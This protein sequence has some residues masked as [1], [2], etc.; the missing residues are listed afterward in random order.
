MLQEFNIQLI[1]MTQEQFATEVLE[2]MEP[3]KQQ[4]S[5]ALAR[6]LVARAGGKFLHK[7]TD[8]RTKPDNSAGEFLLGREPTWGDIEAGTAVKR[9]FEGELKGLIDKSDDQLTIVTGTAGTGKS[10]TLMRLALT[11]VA[12]G[13]GV[14][15]L[16][17][18]V[19]VPR[20]HIRNE[21]REAKPDILFIDDADLFNLNTAALLSD[22]VSDNTDMLLVAGMRSTRY[23][24]VQ[25]EVNLKDVPFNFYAVPYLE[26]SDI[27]LLLDALTRANRLGALRGLTR[28]QQ[29]SAFR[30]EAGRQLLVAMIQATSNERFDDKVDSECQEL[31]N[32]LGLIYATVALATSLRNFLTRDEILFS[33]GDM[34]NEALNRVQSLLKQ[35]LLVETNLNQIRVRHRVIAEKA[36]DYY[37]KNGQLREPIR[38]LLWTMATR[39]Q[40][41]QNGHSRESLLLSQ[42]MSHEFMIRLTDDKFTPRIAY[43]DVE[44]VLAWNYHYYLQRGSYEVEIGDLDLAKN[45]LDQARS[46]APDDYKVQTEWAYMTLKRASRDAASVGA[47]ERAEEAFKELEDA[48]SRRGKNDSYPYHVIGSQGLAW[49]RRAII[50]KEEKSRLLTRLRAIADEG[51]RFH[52]KQRDLQKL[53]KDLEREYLMLAVPGF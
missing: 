22:L 29:V 39:V 9:E 35:H 10:T 21:V 15:W 18:D 34:T 23:E 13:K 52:P 45:F 5:M 51:V 32:E 47:G 8:L 27:E 25:V 7:V 49:A 16:D 1:E 19:D 17:S 53:A 48:I 40:P 4:G 3:E 36:L 28:E 37:R 43:N 12:E 41:D 42:V 44:D 33:I 14:W 50:S 20:W 38:G 46:L 2:Q 11:Y 6:R 26:D 31:G 30:R 24:K